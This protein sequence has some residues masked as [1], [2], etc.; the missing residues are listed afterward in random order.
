MGECCSNS[1]Y[2]LEKKIFESFEKIEKNKID[3]LNIIT[4]DENCKNIF[5]KFQKYI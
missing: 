1:N 5:E 3:N 2:P 4:Y